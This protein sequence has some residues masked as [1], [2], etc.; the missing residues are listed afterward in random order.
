MDMND[1]DSSQMM[2]EYLSYERLKNELRVLF[3]ALDIVLSPRECAEVAQFIDVAE[4][5]IAL[6]SIAGIIVE[7][8]RKL[9][10]ATFQRMA[11]LARRM[12]IEESVVTNEMRACVAESGKPGHPPFS[13]S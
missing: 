4:Y 2:D 9:T 6:E 3:S 5:G 7:G 8:Q 11:D 1:L 12:D 13:I 10:P